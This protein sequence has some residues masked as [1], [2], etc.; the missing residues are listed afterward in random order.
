MGHWNDKYVIGITG[1]IATGKSLVRKMLQHLGAYTIDADGLAHQIMAPNAPAY[2]PAI[3]W[4]GRWIVDGE[5]RIDREK[6]GAVAFSHTEAL[7]RLESI[8]H[9]IIG[10]AIDTL[11][12]RSKKQLV[13]VEAIKLLEGDLA[14]KVDAIWVVDSTIEKQLERL[15]KTRGLSEEEARK[16]IAVQNPQAD[17]IKAAHL[18]IP[19]NGDPNETFEYVK[20][21]L[22]SRGSTTD[23]SGQTERIVAIDPAQARGT[24][25]TKVRELKEIKIRRPKPSHFGA[26]ANLLNVAKG[27]TLT[28]DDIMA[29]FSET[30]YLAAESDDEIVGVIGFVVENLITQSSAVS[31]LPDV[32]IEPV[33]VALIKEMEQAADDL[34]SEVSFIYLNRG[35]SAEVIALLQNQLEYELKEKVEDIKVPAWREA[36]RSSQPEGTVILFKKL[37]EERILTP[38]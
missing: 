15:M 34:Q 26:I 16:R 32:P 11:V 1:N 9:P 24:G 13:A 5:G 2:R 25:Q 20:A 18:V 14:S 8:T 6:L 38:F 36:V 22:A 10:R 4:F 30:S 21:G 23:E 31:F 7:K 29:S 17:K 28:A 19:N 3:E 27:S 37:R 33:L 35:K 12:G